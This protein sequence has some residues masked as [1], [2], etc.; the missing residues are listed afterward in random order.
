[1]KIVF[2]PKE[3]NPEFEKIRD[4]LID[5]KPE[6]KSDLSYVVDGAMFI[7]GYRLKPEEKLKEVINKADEKF[8]VE[9]LKEGAENGFFQATKDLSSLPA[10]IQPFVEVPDGLSKSSIH[11]LLSYKLN[12]IGP[13]KKVEFS[14]RDEEHYTLKERLEEKDML[15]CN[16]FISEIN[17]H[18]VFEEEA[19]GD[20]SDALKTVNEA[21]SLGYEVELTPINSKK[22]GKIKIKENVIEVILLFLEKDPKYSW[23]NRYMSL[24]VPIERLSEIERMNIRCEVYD[25]LI[26]SCGD[27][28]IQEK[29][30]KEWLLSDASKII[31]EALYLAKTTYEED[32]VVGDFSL[33][34]GYIEIAGEKIDEPETESAESHKAIY[35]NK[36]A[37][38]YII[39]NTL[40]TDSFYSFCYNEDSDFWSDCEMSGLFETVF[41]QEFSDNWVVCGSNT[42]WQGSGF[43]DNIV[44]NTSP[45]AIMEKIVGGCNDYTLSIYK[46]FEERKMIV[47]KHH[48]D[49]PTGSCYTVVAFEDFVKRWDVK[50]IRVIR[51]ALGMFDK[52]WI[53]DNFTDKGKKEIDIEELKLYIATGEEMERAEEFERR[54]ER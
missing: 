8:L 53:R 3:K 1:M 25:K 50:P 38:K 4:F 31:E 9:Y 23:N 6:N 20:G 17:S 54:E 52:K 5:I 34:D 41:G 7:F 47:I 40:G 46:V 12:Y 21:L 24:D 18:N 27:T 35:E 37:C 15:E 16:K 10:L 43:N 45:K 11:N 26:S 36:E 29:Y 44:M 14:E 42:N 39:E 2:E 30:W 19:E 28:S 49:C 51:K 22:I 13:Y 48:H 33:K 32:V